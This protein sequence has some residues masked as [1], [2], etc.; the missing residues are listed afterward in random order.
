MP[1]VDVHQAKTH[2]SRLLARVEAGEEAVIARHGS[3]VA[4]LVRRKPRGK[5]QFGAL[6]EGKV[7]MDDSFFGPLPEDE[8][9]SW[10]GG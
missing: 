8:W 2:P 10:E 9:K 7:V 1:V 3:P 6:K 5:R 4:R